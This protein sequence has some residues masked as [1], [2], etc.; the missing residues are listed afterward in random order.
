M[1]VALSPLSFTLDLSPSLPPSLSL[2]LSLSPPPRALPG[3]LSPPLSLSLS[4]SF[5]GSR[6]FA[7]PLSLSRS[8][9]PLSRAHT[10]ANPD[11]P[12]RPSRRLPLGPKVRPVHPWNRPQSLTPFTSKTCDKCAHG[13]HA[14]AARPTPR[15]PALARTRGYLTM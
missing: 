8:R 7:F 1:V 15:R 3:P 11:E 10:P 6:S 13:V 4:L 14:H 12:Q 2:S 5:C 9:P